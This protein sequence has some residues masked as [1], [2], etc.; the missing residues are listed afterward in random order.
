MFQLLRHIAITMWVGIMVGDYSV[1][2][3][4]YLVICACINVQFMCNKTVMKFPIAK[5]LCYTNVITHLKYIY[6]LLLSYSSQS[7]ISTINPLPMF[8]I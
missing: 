2:K 3:W 8:H 6:F 1:E 7:T 4:L 5:I